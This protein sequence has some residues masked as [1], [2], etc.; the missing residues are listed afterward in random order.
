[1]PASH[2]VRRLGVAAVLCGGCI[3]AVEEPAEPVEAPFV[4]TEDD[5]AGFSEWPTWEL[6]DTGL[7]SGHRPGVGHL[8][9]RRTDPVPFAEPLPVGTILVKTVEDGEPA[10]WEIHAMV[11]RGGDYNVEGSHGWEWLDL[12]IGPDGAPRVFWR[13][14]GTPANPGTYGPDTTGR[15]LGCNDCHAAVPNN[16]YVFLR[17]LI[18]P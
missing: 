4:A 8:H 2:V 1:M 12:R 18:S 17:G 6:P 9:V 16:D 3:A 10:D 7:R 5:F 13:G 15:P 11:K 14:P